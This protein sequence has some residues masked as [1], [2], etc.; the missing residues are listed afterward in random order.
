[1]GFFKRKC[2]KKYSLNDRINYHT[3]KIRQLVNKH[4]TSSGGIN[5]DA[6][7]KE[8]SKSKKLQYSDGFTHMGAEST[9][10]NKSDAYV[11][12]FN[13]RK[14]AESKAFNYKF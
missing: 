6:Y 9:L 8:I 5:F 10:I 1:M 14:K 12:G 11:K 4:R 3:N 7:E 2:K 13:A